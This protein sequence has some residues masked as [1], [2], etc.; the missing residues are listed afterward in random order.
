MADVRGYDRECKDHTSAELRWRALDDVAEALGYKDN[1][2]YNY[3]CMNNPDEV[4]ERLDIL[5]K[6]VA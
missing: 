3:A 2:A 5:Y 1:E 4:W 6:T